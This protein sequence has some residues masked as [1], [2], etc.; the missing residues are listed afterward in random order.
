MMQ[1]GNIFRKW[2]KTGKEEMNL[3]IRSL[4]TDKR[5]KDG[6]AGQIRNSWFRWLIL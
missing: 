1:Q 4:Q 3:R 2:F 6:A 5:D